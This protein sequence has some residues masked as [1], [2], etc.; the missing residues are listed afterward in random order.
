MGKKIHIDVTKRVI[1][2][3]LCGGSGQVLDE[4]TMEARPCWPCNGTGK[5][6]E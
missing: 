6:N 2:C 3:D 1:T 4:N 5:V